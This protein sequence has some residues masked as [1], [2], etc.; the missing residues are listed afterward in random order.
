ML[1]IKQVVV[2]IFHHVT[3]QLVSL[4]S[5]FQL[6]LR[7]SEYSSVSSLAELAT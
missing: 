5:I 1:I 4:L 7:T 3:W 2:V 6:I